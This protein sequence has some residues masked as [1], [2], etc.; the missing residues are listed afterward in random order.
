MRDWKQLLQQA[1]P[2]GSVVKQKKFGI[3]SASRQAADSSV[4]AALEQ[5][6]PSSNSTPSPSVATA[7]PVLLLPV[8]FPSLQ[9]HKAPESK[10]TDKLLL[11]LLSLQ[12]KTESLIRRFQGA[13]STFNGGGG[14][15]GGGGVS[16]ATSLTGQSAREGSSLLTTAV[17]PARSWQ[18]TLA[19]LKQLQ[20]NAEEVSGS[21]PA[22]QQASTLMAI[23]KIAAGEQLPLTAVMTPKRLQLLLQLLTSDTAVAVLS[24]EILCRN[25]QP[26]ARKVPLLF[27]AVSTLVRMCSVQDLAMEIVG[28][29]GVPL[30]VAALNVAPAAVCQVMTTASSSTIRLEAMLVLARLSSRNVACQQ[31]AVREGVVPVL[32]DMMRTGSDEERCHSARLLAILGQ[33]ESTHQVKPCKNY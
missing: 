22:S 5:H 1:P 14:G 16:M 25:P 9:E 30:L 28:K 4:E 12:E 19:R 3:L 33:H 2:P 23:V 15:G 26:E 18:Q 11:Q 32:L 20:Q 7:V 27:F 8:P 6:T 17:S 21:L 29:G 13:T 10:P 24:A 31:D